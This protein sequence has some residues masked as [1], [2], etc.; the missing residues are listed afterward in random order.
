MLILYTSPEVQAN[1]GRQGGFSIR[2][3]RE[4]HHMYSTVQKS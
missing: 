1:T 4:I 2:V 3:H